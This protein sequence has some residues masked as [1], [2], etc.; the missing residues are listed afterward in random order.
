MEHV[1]RM[2]KELAELEDKIKKATE[3]YGNELK[4]PKFTNEQQR[5][6]LFT[7]IEIMKKYAEILSARIV[8]ELFLEAKKEN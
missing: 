1:E 8:F 5:T 7:Q 4:E 3:F 2:E 6:L